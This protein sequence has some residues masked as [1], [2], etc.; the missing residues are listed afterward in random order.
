MVEQDRSEDVARVDAR[1]TDVARV[2]SRS[3]A[4]FVADILQDA[5]IRTRVVADDAGGVLPQLDTT[6]GGVHVEVPGDDVEMA[7]QLLADLE[8]LA[9]GDLIETHDPVVTW[10]A[11]GIVLLAIVMALTVGGA[12]LP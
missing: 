6:T 11:T 7:R 1:W 2:P 3:V 4:G 9:P 8:D 10:R 12:F 5:G